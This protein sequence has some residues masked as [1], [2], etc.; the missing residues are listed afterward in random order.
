MLEDQVRNGSL[1]SRRVLR[2]KLQVIQNVVREGREGFLVESCRKFNMFKSDL[3]AFPEGTDR[4]RI[5][6]IVLV[7]AVQELYRETSL[8]LFSVVASNC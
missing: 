2:G 4:L 3:G 6:V 7:L 1:F 5:G 8:V